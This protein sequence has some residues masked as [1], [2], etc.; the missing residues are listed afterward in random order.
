MAQL[1]VMRDWRKMSR[2]FDEHESQ[3]ALTTPSCELV[4]CVCVCVCVGGV[5]SL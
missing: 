5:D 3:S 2:S 4:E 1:T